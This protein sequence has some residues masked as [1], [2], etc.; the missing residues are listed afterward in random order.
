MAEKKLIPFEYVLA[1][2]AAWLARVRTSFVEDGMGKE[3]VIFGPDEGAQLVEGL[4]I[5]I[6]NLGAMRDT[7]MP[8]HAQH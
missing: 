8:S 5:I 4:R 1:E 2:S 3:T 6:S 7:L